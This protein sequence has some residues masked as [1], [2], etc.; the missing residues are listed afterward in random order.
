M[1]RRTYNLRRLKATWPYRIE[2]IAELFGIHKNVVGRWIKQGLPVNRER[3]PFLIR[4]DD[5]AWFLS[6]RQQ[7]RR[8]K[9]GDDQFYCFRCR[10]PRR[11]YLGIADVVVESPTRLRLSA[12]CAVCETVVNK[13][14]AASKLPKLRETFEIQQLTGEHLLE[15]ARSS[16]NGDLETQL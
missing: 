10:E 8:R 11:A 6:A 4:G 16:V 14:Q 2:E 12:L 3:R 5:L 9:C 15:R 1:G 13:V 7:S